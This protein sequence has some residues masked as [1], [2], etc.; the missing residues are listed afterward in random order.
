MAL[1]P[2]AVRTCSLVHRAT[3]VICVVALLHD[4]AAVVDT[5]LPPGH[6]RP[7]VHWSGTLDRSHEMESLVV[8]LS[9]SRWVVVQIR[10][11]PS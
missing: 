5:G 8:G 2:L 1:A 10:S 7:H 4:G 6:L 3:S 11:K 9:A